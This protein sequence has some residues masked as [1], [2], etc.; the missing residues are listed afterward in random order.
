MTKERVVY[1]NGEMVPES[2]AVI[3]I[4]DSGFV[5][6]D[7]VFD[8]TRTFN[9][10]VFKMK[11]HIDRLYASARYLRIDPRMS[12]EKMAELTPRE[13]KVHYNLGQLYKQLAPEASAPRVAITEY[14][15]GRPG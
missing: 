10:V 11:E 9:G 6:G 1:L 7:A 15:T 2:K 14:N 5:S 4:H 3:S 8:N 13:A 12:K